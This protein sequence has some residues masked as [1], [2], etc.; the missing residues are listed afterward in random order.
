MLPRDH[1]LTDSRDFSAVMRRGTRAGTSAAVVTVLLREHGDHDAGRE[2]TRWRGGFV[3]SKAVGNAVVRH[4]T[5]RRLRHILREL[6][7][8]PGMLPEGGAADVV[9]RAL[10]ESPETA[11]DQ[12]RAEVRSGLRR[13]LKKAQR[14]RSGSDA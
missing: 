10:K 3:V 2:K 6:M 14:Q 7:E 8:E 9:V 1:R 5:Q 11:H 12:L 4:R 13:A